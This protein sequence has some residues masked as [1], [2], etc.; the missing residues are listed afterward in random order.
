MSQSSQLATTWDVNA[1]QVNLDLSDV[2]PLI[3]IALEPLRNRLRQEAAVPYAW[4]DRHPLRFRYWLFVK[5][6]R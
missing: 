2:A 1:D 4:K 6:V 5:A 3:V